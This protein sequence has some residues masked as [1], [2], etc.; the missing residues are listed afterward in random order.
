MFN[1]DEKPWSQIYM[2]HI[3]LFSYFLFQDSKKT[4]ELKRKT[5][6]T[7]TSMWSS[8]WTRGAYRDT[9]E[10]RNRY[11]VSIQSSLPYLP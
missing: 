8:F 11:P 9:E 5:E 4:S 7:S 1:K 2:S 3:S 6:N 10:Y